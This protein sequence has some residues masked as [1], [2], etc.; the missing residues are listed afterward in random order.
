MRE[1]GA[2]GQKTLGKNEKE[3]SAVGGGSNSK[4]M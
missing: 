2:K 1:G 3:R 4:R